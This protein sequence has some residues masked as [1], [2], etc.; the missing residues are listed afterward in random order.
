MNRWQ[1]LSILSVFCGLALTGLDAKSLGPE[2]CREVALHVGQHVAAVSQGESVSNLLADF[3][4]VTSVTG[5]IQPCFLATNDWWKISLLCLLEAWAQEVFA[6]SIMIAAGG[7]WW[8]L[9]GP[10]AT[11]KFCENNVTIC[12]TCTSHVL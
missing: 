11:V 6:G 7:S 12:R 4:A 5:C 9:V 8:A 3:P 10:N 2:V 1:W